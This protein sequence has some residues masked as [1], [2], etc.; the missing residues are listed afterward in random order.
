[1]PRFEFESESA[2]TPPVTKQL[3]SWTN[4]MFP[5]AKI[6]KGV[7]YAPVVALFRQPAQWLTLTVTGSHK[8]RASAVVTGA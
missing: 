4:H 2:M 1:M 5:R 8:Y 3:K 6:E 7:T